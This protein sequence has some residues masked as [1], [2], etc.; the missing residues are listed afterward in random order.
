MTFFGIYDGHMGCQ[1]STYVYENILNNVL[2]LAERSKTVSENVLGEAIV[3]T[4]SGYQ[5]MV[6][7]SNDEEKAA[8]STVGSCCL[9]GILWRNRMFVANLGDSQA[10]VGRFVSNRMVAVA[11]NSI[12]NTKSFEERNRYENEHPEDPMPLVYT[13][14][15]W[16]VKGILPVTRTIGDTYL[17]LDEYRVNEK[18]SRFYYGGD[19]L[20]RPLL[21]SDPQTSSHFVG[22]DDDFVI[23]AS[24]GFWAHLTKDEAVYI[25]HKYPRLG[26]AA[27]LVKRAMDKALIIE[28]SWTLPMGRG[29]A[30][31]MTVVVI[32]MDWKNRGPGGSAKVYV[33]VR[34]S[35]DGRLIDDKASEDCI[36][37]STTDDRVCKHLRRLEG[38]NK[39]LEL[40]KIAARNERRA[41]RNQI[42]RA[43]V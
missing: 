8:V 23:I 25:I 14:Y 43:H 2:D 19:P 38:L 18:K 33:S 9:I 16:R 6:R 36:V 31:D 17:K 1:A 41:A 42:G 28:K 24:H 15:S 21:S 12:H 35:E 4:E 7:A 13:N 39:M 22:N 37:E 27:R 10:V 30:D 26:I 20:S 11:L 5:E 34:S 32:F 3:A 40:E 29:H